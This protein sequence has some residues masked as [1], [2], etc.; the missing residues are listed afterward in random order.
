MKWV[1]V[2]AIWHFS[3]HSG[4]GCKKTR[5]RLCG[6]YWVEARERWSIPCFGHDEQEG[7]D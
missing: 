2:H 6:V 4:D 3:E 7:T 5:L 1:V